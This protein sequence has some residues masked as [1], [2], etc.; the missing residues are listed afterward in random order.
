M[1]AIMDYGLGNIGSIANMLSKIGEKEICFA[2]TSEELINADKIILPGVGSFDAGMMMLNE[3]GMRNELDVQVIKNHKPILGICLGMQMLGLNSEEGKS[4]GLGY[5]DFHCAKFPDELLTRKLRIPHMGWDY[6]SLEK[7]DQ[8]TS[9]FYE[10]MKFYFVHS[11]YAI[12]NNEE[13]VLFSCDYGFKF[14]AGVSRE[15]IYGVQFHP[16]KSHKYG[17]KLLENFVRI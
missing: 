2:K 16:E 3:S 14:T 5:I 12:C 17:M 1:I 7:R 13:D 6:I 4:A 8:I 9:D 11:Y 10:D 15:N